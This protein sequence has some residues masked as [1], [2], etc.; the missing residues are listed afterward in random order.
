M[1][2]QLVI[3]APLEADAIIVPLSGGGR[4]CPKGPV[5]RTSTSSNPTPAALANTA[6]SIQVTAS[7]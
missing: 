2:V 1:S 3:E 4:R 6:W 7:A 5:T